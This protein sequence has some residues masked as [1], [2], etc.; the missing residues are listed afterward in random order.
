MLNFIHWNIDPI[1]T[2]LGSFEI[3]Y[4]SLLF[5]GSFVA[6]YYLLLNIFKKENIDQMLL[7]KLV[8]YIFLATIIG[9]RLGNCIFYEPDYYLEHPLE[10]FLP[11]N[12]K[13]EFVGYRG[14]ASHGAAFGIVLA[15]YLYNKNY[16]MSLLEVCDKVSPMI[17]LTAASVRTGNLM[18]SEIIGKPSEVPWAF[19]FDRI[20]AIP[21]HPSQI[22]EGLSY[23]IIFITLLWVYHNKKQ[24]LQKGA[25]AGMFLVGLF[26]TRFIIEY[27]KENQEPFEE[28]MIINMGQILSIPFIVLGLYL[29]T[30]NNIFQSWDTKLTNSEKVSEVN[31]KR[32]SN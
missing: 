29:L 30:K 3:R 32:K 12:S 1:I 17:A 8:Y 10:I 21:R 13:M 11:F 27:F 26:V 14:L 19:I 2:Q 28:G 4:Y 24:N 15:L 20:D 16:K 25:I 18:N 9:A 5:G 31:D 23:F 6:G 7:D 22:Y